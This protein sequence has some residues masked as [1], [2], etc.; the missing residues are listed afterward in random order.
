MW[1]PLSLEPRIEW[2]NS[3]RKNPFNREKRMEENSG[4]ATEEGSFSWDGQICNRWRAY[5]INQQQNH[6]VYNFD[7]R[8]VDCRTKVKNIDPVKDIILKISIFCQVTIYHQMMQHNGD[9]AYGPLMTTWLTCVWSSIWVFPVSASV[10]SR[11]TKNW[12]EVQK[13][14]RNYRLWRRYRKRQRNENLRDYNF[15]Q[16]KIRNEEF[17]LMKLTLHVEL[18]YVMKRS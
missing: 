4:W 17:R 11:L 18:K 6:S 13:H 14:T 16:V 10:V 3:P 8:N 7:D 5:R 15:K 1:H 12:S 9:W 2:G